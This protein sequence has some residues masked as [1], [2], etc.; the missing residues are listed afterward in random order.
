MSSV[1]AIGTAVYDTILSSDK[2]FDDAICNKVTRSFCDGGAIRNVAHNLT[3]LK[4]EVLFW[5]KFGNDLEALDMIARLE[6]LGIQVHAKIIDMPS[7][8][9]YQLFD[10]DSSMMISSTTDDFYFNSQDTLPAFL[11]RNEAFGITDQ[12]DPEFLGNLIKRHPRLRWIALGFLP[13]IDLQS[14]FF[15]VF[16]NRKEALRNAES[17]D[18]FF[19][20]SKSIPLSVVTLDKHG[21]LYTYEGQTERLAA[22]VMGNGNALGMGD[23]LVAGFLHFYL[24][25]FAVES[26][27]TFGIEC[28]RQTSGVTTAIN[29][30]LSEVT[31]L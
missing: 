26:C 13:P 31:K 9:F 12:D 2:S 4:D 25:G 11:L 5:A 21:L 22:P 24:K 17:I 18:K 16:V 23:A 15:A 1:I 6:A 30:A 27:L 28:A 3:L 29:P 20:K 10:A 19:V 14:S 7:P 8:H